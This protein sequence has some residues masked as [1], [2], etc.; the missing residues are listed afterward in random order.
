MSLNIYEDDNGELIS[1]LNDNRQSVTAQ[2]EYITNN[3]L[4]QKGI[5]KLIEMI[6]DFYNIMDSMNVNVRYSFATASLRKINNCD[7]VLTVVKNSTG[8]D[9]HI[10]SGEDEAYYGFIAVKYRDITDYDEGLIIDIGGG[11]SEVVDFII[12]NS[13]TMES[14]PIGS[15]SCYE[16]YVSGMFPNE[17]EI[18]N[19]QNRVEMELAKLV[20]NHTFHVDNLY[21]NGGTIYTIKRILIYLGYIDNQTWVIPSSTL[22]NLLTKLMENSTETER[23]IN[24]IDPSRLYTL[25]PGLIIAKQI[26]THFNVSY[27]H[28][29]RGMLEEGVAYRLIEN[30]TRD[31]GTFK[32]LQDKINAAT[33]GSII[34]L[35]NDYTNKGDFSIEGI[36]ITK[37]IIIEG[38]GFTIDASGYS[39]I[40]NIYATKNL[41]LNNLIFKG[42]FAYDGGAIIFNNNISDSVIRNCYFLGNN[43]NA[44]GGALSFNGI[45]N[46]TIEKT[47]FDYNIAYGNGGAINVNANVLNSTINN[48]KFKNNSA[49]S[50]T[51]NIVLNRDGSFNLE[52]VTPEKLNPYYVAY[53]TILNVTDKITYGEAVVI[54]VKVED[55]RYGLLNNGTIS[56]IAKGKNYTA[57]VKNGT[58]HLE[59]TGLNAGSYSSIL[60]YVNGENY[61]NPTQSVN[62]K[63]LKQKAVITANNKAYTIN[64]GGKYSIMLKDAKGKAIVAKNLRFILN[65]ENIGLAKTNSQGVATIKLTAKIL[66]TAK[67]GKKNLIIKF[68]DLNYNTVSK[69]VKI[70]INKEKTIMVAK[71][72]TFKK[73]QKVKE[74]SVILKNSKNK[75][76]KNVKCT[77]MIQGKKYT[78]KTNNNGKATF[79]IMNLKKKGYFK[80]IVK[81]SGNTYYKAVNKN[82]KI[83]IL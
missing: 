52:N 76:V 37:P 53:L 51:N 74:Y 1:L 11:S 43:A 78:A 47:T 32:E 8:I 2:K 9:L 31:N 69:T 46:I 60:S 58:A 6:T 3:S 50:G 40:L 10:L 36:N 72:K 79:K 14:M 55:N 15:R 67:S 81:F 83:K 19:I 63:V 42:G 22:D 54:I 57:N 65:G 44:D 27:V 41:V 39:R 13:V 62:F 59:I 30:N 20:V 26:S 66:K 12:K 34:Y 68:T 75:A 71:K 80:V 18:L 35:R 61:T 5:E 45:T 4:N 24:E 29:C 17:T 56:I 70:T 77:L 23:I 49:S 7:E 25:M 33:E 73:Y 38:N 82:V 64:Y 21:G 48:S 16:E 28:F